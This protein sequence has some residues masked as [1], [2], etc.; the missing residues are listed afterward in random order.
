MNKPTITSH[1]E[2]E[3]ALERLDVI[4]VAKPGDKD[5]DERCDLVEAVVEY[6][7]ENF[8]IDEPTKAMMDIF[9]EDQEIG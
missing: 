1:E 4:W 6:E 3:N 7:D 2:L 5:W 9:K 8:K